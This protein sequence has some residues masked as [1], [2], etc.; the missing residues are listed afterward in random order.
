MSTASSNDE[1]DTSASQSSDLTVSITQLRLNSSLS[2][3]YDLNNQASGEKNWWLSKDSLGSLGVE[4]ERLP[5]VLARDVTF[6]RFAKRVEIIKARR[7]FDYRNGT[8]TIIELP[9]GEHEVT[10]SKFSRQFT[11]AFNNALAQDDIE[12]W[13]AKSLYTNLLSDEYEEPDACFI[14]KPHIITCHFKIEFG[15]VYANGRESHFCTGPHMKWIT[16]NRDCIYAGCPQPPQLPNLFSVISSVPFRPPQF[17]YPLQT[18]GVAI[19]LYDIQQ[20]IFQAMGP[21]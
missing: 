5:L 9:T 13:G 3:S 18:S 19:D 1:S 7:F 2:S 21:N 15:S 4:E 14:P 8:I 6:S 12:D 11:S 20:S 17:P 16:I 10:H